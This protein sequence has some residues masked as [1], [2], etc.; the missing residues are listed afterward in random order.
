MANHRMSC[1]D[2]LEYRGV[3]ALITGGGS[4]I[5]R[6]FATE[7]SRYG[8][9]VTIVGKNGKALDDTISFLGQSGPNCSWKMAVDLGSEEAAREVINRTVE[10]MGGMDL[11]V[12]ATAI[13]HR[14]GR[15]KEFMQ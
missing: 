15:D 1:P 3:K 7:L 6:A 4:G 5:G 14:E 2:F 8:A 13:V 11:V 9:Q 10:W 12:N